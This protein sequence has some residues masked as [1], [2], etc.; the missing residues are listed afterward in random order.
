MKMMRALIQG[1]YARGRQNT[2]ARFA[3]GLSR[4]L[5][6]TLSDTV[7]IYIKTAHQAVNN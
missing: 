1:D 4:F 5:F 2:K 6:L 3:T 7:P